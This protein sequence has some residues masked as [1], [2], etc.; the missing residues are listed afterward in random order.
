MELSDAAE[1]DFHELPFIQGMFKS[2]SSEFMNSFEMFSSGTFMNSSLI[3]L[4][5][6]LRK[7][8][9]VRKTLCAFIFHFLATVVIG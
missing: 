1:L 9:F 3:N 8:K 6:T 5:I 2:L 4:K 7:R